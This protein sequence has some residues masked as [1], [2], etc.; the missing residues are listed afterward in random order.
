MATARQTRS[1]KLILDLL[2]HRSQP[3]SA[4]EIFVELRNE[5]QSVGLAT[6]YRSLEAL[7]NEGQ[8]QA[9]NLG[10]T[11]PITKC[12]PAMDITD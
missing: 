11:S 9:V 5:Q 3:L 2:S 12:S 4:Q 6:V 10:I 7:Q 1:Q 8:L